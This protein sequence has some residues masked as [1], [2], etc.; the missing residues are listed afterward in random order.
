MERFF[1]IYRNVVRGVA[2]GLLL[3]VLVSY[4]M[5]FFENGG[6]SGWMRRIFT[7]EGW[8]RA[9]IPFCREPSSVEEGSVFPESEEDLFV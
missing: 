8:R 2:V 5:I 1:G 9:E 4:L 6:F 3:M 7:D